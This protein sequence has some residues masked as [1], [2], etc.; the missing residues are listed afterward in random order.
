MEYSTNADAILDYLH[1]ESIEL[2]ESGYCPKANNS[3]PQPETQPESNG[4]SRS[5]RNYLTPPEYAKRLGIHA[6]RVLSWIR[7]GRR[8]RSRVFAVLHGIGLIV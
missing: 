4:E 2:A 3:K 8:N 5:Q 7:S 1:R 6:D